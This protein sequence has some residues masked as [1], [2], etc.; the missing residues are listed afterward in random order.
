MD[1]GWIKLSRQIQEHWIWQ[2]PEKLKAWIDLILMANHEDAEVALREGVVKVKRGQLITSIGKLAE[3]WGWSKDR[4]RRFLRLLSDTNMVTRKI[5]T[6]K[7]TLT[8][9]NYGKFQDRPT[10]DK[11]SNK[12]SS[13]TSNKTSDKTRTRRNKNKEEYKES[14]TLTSDEVAVAYEEEDEDDDTPPVPGAKRLPN[15]GWDY[16]PD[17]DWG[18]E[19]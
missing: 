7:T 2:D 8:I 5:D 15:G 6:H 14:D 3:R 13:K 11:T 10:T 17:L 4:V 19:D 12:T 16:R 9:I 1:K 18:D